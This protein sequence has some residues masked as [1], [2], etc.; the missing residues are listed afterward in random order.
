VSGG[1]WST[2]LC[3]ANLHAS[4]RPPGQTERELLRAARAALEW[5]AG[6]PILLGGDFNLRPAAAPELYER[7]ERELGFSAPTAPDAIDHL[8]VRGLD[9]LRAPARWPAERRDLELRV[10]GGS[11]RVRLSDHAPVEARF[12]LRDARCDTT[13]VD[14]QENRLNSG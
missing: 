13:S 10:D 1:W 2:E 5:A 7:L 9:V 8:L 12:A 3:V 11:R 4:S 6:T 14:G